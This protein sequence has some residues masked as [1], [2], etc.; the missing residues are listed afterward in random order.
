[1]TREAVALP[2]SRL[3][4]TWSNEMITANQHLPLPAAGEGRGEGEPSRLPRTW[5][6]EKVTANQHLPVPAAGETR[7]EGQRREGFLSLQNA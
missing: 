6:H 5:C 2:P 3:P 1:M 4:R 7:G